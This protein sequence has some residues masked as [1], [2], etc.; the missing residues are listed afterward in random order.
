[1]IAPPPPENPVDVIARI[2]GQEPG[3]LPVSV[4]ESIWK[5]AECSK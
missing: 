4:V 5:I 3:G 2:V 1:L